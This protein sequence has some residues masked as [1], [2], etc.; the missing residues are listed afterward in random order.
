MAF[1]LSK[2]VSYFVS[3]AAIFAVGSAIFYLYTISV[4]SAF[5]AW[6]FAIVVGC[7]LLYTLLIASVTMLASTVV[8][9]S[10]AAGGVGL[11]SYIFF[12]TVFELFKPLKEY[13]PNTI[14]SVYKS[15][16]GKGWNT[17]LLFPVILSVVL[18]VVSVMLAVLVF[19]RQE[20]ER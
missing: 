12:A 14:F 5:N 6:Y 7:V 10:I 19:R 18:I 20:V 15:V 13:S 1:V 4:F 9:N 8:K 3:I 11:I 17:D 2:F 16:I